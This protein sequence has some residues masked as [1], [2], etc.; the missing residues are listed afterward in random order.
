M[1]KS[2]PLKTSCESPADTARMILARSTYHSIRHVSCTFC[3][4]VLILGG[5]VPNYHMKQIAQT[6]V[7]GICGVSQ[8]EN[9]IEVPT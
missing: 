1:V 3:N 4:G 5:N 2:T 7:Q 8:I 9:R 6:S